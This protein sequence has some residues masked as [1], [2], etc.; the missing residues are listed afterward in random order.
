MDCI[1]TRLQWKGSYGIRKEDSACAEDDGV[2]PV[3]DLSLQEVEGVNRAAECLMSAIQ[4]VR[5]FR[6]LLLIGSTIS[7]RRI[8]DGYRGA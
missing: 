5:G 8:V 1:C 3:V 2:T 6:R 7:Y 4:C